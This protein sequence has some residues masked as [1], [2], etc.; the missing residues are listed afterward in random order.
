MT[1][2]GYAKQLCPVDT[3]NLRNSIT[4]T[5]KEDE[6]A[7]YI[8]R[9]EDEGFVPKGA[10]NLTESQKT[11]LNVAYAQEGKI[12]FLG[13]VKS[14]NESLKDH[15]ITETLKSVDTADENAYEKSLQEQ[16]NKVSKYLGLKR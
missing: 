11:A 10:V 1:A 14:L 16:I 5:V 12:G 4:H 7:A 3:G 8:E 6:K 15:F 13:A 2:E 9:V